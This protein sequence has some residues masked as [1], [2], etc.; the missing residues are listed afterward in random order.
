MFLGQRSYNT[1]LNGMQW[2]QDSISTLKEFACVE[3]EENSKAVE[4]NIKHFTDNLR[5]KFLLV[6]NDTRL[7][8][9]VICPHSNLDHLNHSV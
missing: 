2:Q 8:R 1:L 3:N 6:A 9:K 7:S 4:W 5:S